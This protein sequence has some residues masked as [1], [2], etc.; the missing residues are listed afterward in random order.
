MLQVTAPGVPDVPAATPH[1]LAHLVGSAVFHVP[2]M[3]GVFNNN[4]GGGESEDR[5]TTFVS[6]LL[7]YEGVR[8]LQ[9]VVMVTH[10]VAVVHTSFQTHRNRIRLGSPM[11]T[12]RGEMAAVFALCPISD[13]LALC[14]ILA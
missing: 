14:V 6:L 10:V 8:A 2:K 5:V 7:H 11:G 12:F 13:A 4:A 9:S 3:W 1:F